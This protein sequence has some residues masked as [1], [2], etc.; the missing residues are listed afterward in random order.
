VF[1]ERA[2][3]WP[4]L[5]SVKS[6]RI[7]RRVEPFQIYSLRTGISQA[8]RRRAESSE[9][10]NFKK[11]SDSAPRAD[12]RRCCSFIASADVSCEALRRNLIS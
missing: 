1:G 7:E 8:K 2:R 3:N 11:R 9:L 4:S 12:Q 10:P 5:N 6:R